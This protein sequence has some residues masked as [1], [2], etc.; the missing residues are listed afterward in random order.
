MSDPFFL[1]VEGTWWVRRGCVA[2][3]F[4]GFQTQQP[5]PPR[6][7]WQTVFGRLAMRNWLFTLRRGEAILAAR[8][9]RLVE[10]RVSPQSGLAVQLDRVIAF[11]P[12]LE[13]RTRYVR[14]VPLSG[15]GARHA[16]FFSGAGRVIVA[17]IGCL[18]V[19]QV[20]A[21]E[22]DAALMPPDF[23]PDAVVAWSSDLKFGFTLHRL[24][25]STFLS[26]KGFRETRVTFS[27]A[28]PLW[29]DAGCEP[30]PVAPSRVRQLPSGPFGSR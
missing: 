15:A 1:R 3:A 6:P 27:G 11:E 23:D 10:L 28:G 14:R 4:G 13:L 9:L 29:L 21:A 2:A 26:P 8:G 30:S 22:G 17:A 16:G 5:A 24:T 18:E 19:V 20:D 7:W 25:W 12:G